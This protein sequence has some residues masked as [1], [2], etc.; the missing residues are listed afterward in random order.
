MILFLLVLFRGIHIPAPAIGA[1]EFAFLSLWGKI[2]PSWF[3][4]PHMKGRITARTFHH[5]LEDESPLDVVY[6]TDG[7]LPVPVDVQTYGCGGIHSVLLAQVKRRW[8][9]E[10]LGR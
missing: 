6:F 1:L 3:S 8:Q 4:N 7:S 5:I 2:G 9:V 10:H